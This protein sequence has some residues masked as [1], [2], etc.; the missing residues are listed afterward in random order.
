MHPLFNCRAIYPADF[1]HVWS[2]GKFGEKEIAITG[3]VGTH[4]ALFLNCH[5][6]GESTMKPPWAHM[7][8]LDHYEDLMRAGLVKVA[9][10]RIPDISMEDRYRIAEAW[11]R[12]VQGS[13]YDFRGIRQMWTSGSKVWMKDGVLALL[14]DGTAIR[15]K[16]LG[17]KFAHWCTEGLR[18]ACIKGTDGRIDPLANE[19]PTPRTVENR[20]REGKLIDVSPSCLSSAGLQYRLQIPEKVG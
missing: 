5:T 18:T 15:Q 14:P 20:V 7:T 3:G 6:V 4:D 10:L 17:W 16:A 19:N 13:L 2:A 9:I 1:L 8:D 11:C 12:H